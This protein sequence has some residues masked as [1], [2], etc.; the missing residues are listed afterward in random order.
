MYHVAEESKELGLRLV[1][2]PFLALAR[3]AHPQVTVI[4]T[5]DIPTTAG[6]SAGNWW[7]YWLF[8]QD[9]SDPLRGGAENSVQCD[10]DVAS[11]FNDLKKFFESLLQRSNTISTHFFTFYASH[12]SKNGSQELD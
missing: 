12:V 11:F 8:I 3:C 2:L 5:G 4:K 6:K 10:D 9:L 1:R 7:I